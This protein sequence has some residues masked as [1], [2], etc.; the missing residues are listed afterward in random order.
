MV[1]VTWAAMRSPFCLAGAY[2]VL[3]ESVHRGMVQR[4]GPREHLHRFT[5]PDTST[6]ASSVTVTVL[7]L[8]KYRSAEGDAT[9]RT[10]LISFGGTTALP[11]GVVAAKRRTVVATT[12]RRRSY[13]RK[14]DD[15][16]A[17][18]GATTGPWRNLG[19]VD[20][21]T[22]PVRTPEDRRVGR[23]C[24]AAPA[25]GG[26]VSAKPLP[27]EAQRRRRLAKACRNPLRPSRSSAERNSRRER[28]A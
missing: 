27:A 25:A 16:L 20:I 6:K 3:L 15:S 7:P 14:G 2:R 19:H 18:A 1:T 9:A 8:S 4:S 21:R 22:V 10:D 24:A 12:R 13:R 28:G 26:T 23:F 11:E 5:A 17:A